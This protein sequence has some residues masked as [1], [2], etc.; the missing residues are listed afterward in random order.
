MSNR[1]A[2][3]NAYN[4][5]GIG[6]AVGGSDLYAGKTT[7]HG[8]CCTGQRYLFK[9]F[10]VYRSNGACKILAV[11]FA[12]AYNHYF[13]ELGHIGHHHNIYYGARI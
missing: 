1:A 12:I 13:V 4:H 3:A 5:F 8:L 9:V 6:G 10:A 2:A 11:Y 7:G